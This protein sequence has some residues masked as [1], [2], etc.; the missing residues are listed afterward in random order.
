MLKTASR[1][2]SLRNEELRNIKSRDENETENDFRRA[3]VTAKDGDKKLFII[4]IPLT[5]R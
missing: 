2:A 1:A 5:L 3:Q 4:R